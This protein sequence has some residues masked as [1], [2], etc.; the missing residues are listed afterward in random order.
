MKQR[1]DQGSVTVWGPWKGPHSHAKTLF[2]LV[3][4]F[5]KFFFFLSTGA[6]VTYVNSQARG[7]SLQQS[8]ILNPLSKAWN[9]THT[10]LL[11]S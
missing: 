8:Q 9:Q 6:P 4:I 3:Q 11:R 2:S 1:E 10:L 5:L 7:H